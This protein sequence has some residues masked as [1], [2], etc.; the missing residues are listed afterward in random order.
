TQ[1]VVT[2][3]DAGGN[4]IVGDSRTVSLALTTPAGAIL[5]CDTTTVAASS[6][7]APF[8]GCQIDKSGTYTLSATASGVAPGTSTNVVV[9]T[10]PAAR[11]AFTTQPSNGTG[12]VALTTQ[13]VVKVLDSYGNTVT[14]PTNSVALALTTSN[15]AVLTCTTNPL[16]TASGIATFAAC[17]VDKTGTY[18]L[19]AT[20]ASL[21]STVSASFTI[22]VGPAT[23]LGYA[24]QP[25]SSAASQVALANQPVVAVQDAGGN[26]VTTD[27]STVTLALT[28]PGT[29]TLAC[30][31][32]TV[33]GTS[34]LAAFTGCRVDKIGTYSLKAMAPGLTLG[35]S[36]NITIT[37]G[38]AA[39]LGFTTQPS[40]TGTSQVALPTQP[41][42]KIV[43]AGG[44]T[45]TTDTSTV[46]IALTTPN[47]ATLACT[48]SNFRAASAGVATFA[49]CK[50]DKVGTYTLTAT[51][52]SLTSAVSNNITIN[53]AAASR[54]AFTSQPGGGAT[55]TPFASQ[56]T[57][58]VQDASGNTVTSSSSSVTLA[59]TTPNGAV[60][61][62]TTNPLAAS[63]GVAAFG[64]CRVDLPGTYTLTATGTSLT[65][66]VSTSFTVS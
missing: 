63:A 52:G 15:G 27:S 10:G 47:G 58:T 32:T 42:I 29:A 34:G 20:S 8:T 22:A 36:T 6:G 11:L 35:T 23:K 65:S 61:T 55:S 3:Q 39:Q 16:T 53:P 59:L 41:A 56:P 12:G 38:P 62:C 44:N 31:T 30:D 26:T 45:V 2:V 43:D 33:V 48:T 4:T 13:P 51:D 50:I 17:K 7:V 57:V 24:A 18:T 25:S 21:T 64:G 28:T 60:L 14:S 1:P 54:L 19:T 66:A 40:A 49:G 46:T 9:S 5:T 37:V